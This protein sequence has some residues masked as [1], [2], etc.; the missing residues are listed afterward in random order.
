MR[1]KEWEDERN[2]KKNKNNKK[3]IVKLIWQ[4]IKLL[5][6]N[7]YFAFSF[8]GFTFTIIVPSII[9]TLNIM[10]KGCA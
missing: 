9:Y 8:A 3:K 1:E 2:K 10:L 7:S 6:I 5:T 4:D